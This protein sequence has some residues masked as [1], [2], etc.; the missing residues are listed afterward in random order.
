MRPLLVILHDLNLVARYADEVLLLMSGR[1]VATGTPVAVFQPPLLTR[2]FGLPLTTFYH[3]SD[4]RLII[5]PD[6]PSS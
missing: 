1:A 6:V 4:R 2:I 5:A 3:P